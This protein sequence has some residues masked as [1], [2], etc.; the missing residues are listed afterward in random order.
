MNPWHKA[1]AIVQGYRFK[2]Q[3]FKLV[4]SIL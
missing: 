1:G 2:D 4:G 3:G